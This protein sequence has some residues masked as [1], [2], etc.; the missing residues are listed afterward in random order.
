MLMLRQLNQM[1]MIL[2][3]ITVERA[4]R[5]LEAAVPSE[6]I[7]EDRADL[8]FERLSR[9]IRFG[10][11]L[12][13]QLRNGRLE[14]DKKIEAERAAKAVARKARLKKQV[15][16]LVGEA[17]E[18]HTAQ[19][20][21][22][23]IE[24]EDEIYDEQAD[25]DKELAFHEALSDRLEEEDIER[26]L[27]ECPPGEIAAR[28]CRDIKIEPVPLEAADSPPAPE[29]DAV[30]AEDPAPP[31]PEPEVPKPDLP[32]GPPVY[33]IDPM[34]TPEYQRAFREIEARQIA[35]HNKNVS[36]FD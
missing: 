30:E 35:R 5:T 19:E 22:R 27:G 24:S 8:R 20:R 9:S 16:R 34:L 7:A 1:G 12:R 11:M 36:I 3:E 2:T 21:E 28:I 4:R 17:I 26:D 14:Q 13:S 32:A 31:E 25:I 33:T 23:L 10:V 6:P 18:R 29:P 15:E